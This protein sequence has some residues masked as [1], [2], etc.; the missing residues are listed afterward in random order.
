M[1]L[2]NIKIIQKIRKRSL[3]YFIIFL[4]L[5]ALIS[6]ISILF[7]NFGDFEIK[8]LVTTTVIAFFSIACMGCALYAEKNRQPIPAALGAGIGLV[9]AVLIIIGAWAETRSD[10]YWKT[11][12]V[13]SVFGIAAAH[14]FLLASVKLKKGHH[15]VTTTALIGIL[16]NALS[17]SLAVIYEVDEEFILKTIAVFSILSALVTLII[18]ILYRIGKKAEETGQE[19]AADKLILF[20]ESE[21]IYKNNKGERFKVEQIMEGNS[22]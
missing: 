7:G 13:F 11:T 8:I 15:W 20:Q 18:P 22:E 5:S 3:Q 1:E 10:E 19:E 16:C 6:I 14:Y 21:H 12:F 17:I 4:T 2:D 9:A